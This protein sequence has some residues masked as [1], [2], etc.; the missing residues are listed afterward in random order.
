VRSSERFVIR[1]HADRGGRISLRAVI[2]PL[3]RSDRRLRP[4]RTRPKAAV[5]LAAPVVGLTIFRPAKASFYGPGFFGRQT[6]CGLTLTPDLRG[7]AHRSLPC[8]TLVEIM[9]QSRQITVPVIDR[10][11]FSGTYSWDLTQATADALGFQSSGSI[12]YVRADASPAPGPS[13][14]PS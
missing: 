12:G 8:G 9:Y 5:R 2:A 11:P 4:H 10:G 3:S 1:W 6:A 7:V 13:A 14:P